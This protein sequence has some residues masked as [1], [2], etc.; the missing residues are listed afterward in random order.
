MNNHK[1]H[2]KKSFV[3]NAFKLMI[4]MSAMAGTVGIWNLISNKD[5]I[6]AYAQNLETTQVVPPVTLEPLPTLV[7][8]TT[9]DATI[10]NASSTSMPST[11][12]LSDLPNVDIPRPTKQPQIGL[13]DP[14]QAIQNPPA[15]APAPVTSTRSS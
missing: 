14:A 15:A 13:P 4:A 9:V 2:H 7:A 3:P 11:V 12:T 6:Q 1:L 5:L 10:I 8:L